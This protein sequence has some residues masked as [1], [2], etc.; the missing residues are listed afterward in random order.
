ML[1]NAPLVV[2]TNLR[3]TF[4]EDRIINVASRVLTR[5][6][7]HPWHI[8]GKNLLT[9]FHDDWKINLVSRVF[10]RKNAPAPDIIRK[11]V[12]TK[13]HEDW[14][15]NMTFRVKNAPPLTINVAYRGKMTRLRGGHVFQPSGAIFKLV[16][17]IITTNLLTEFHEDRTVNVADKVLTSIFR[18]LNKKCDGKTERQ[19]TSYFQATVTILKLVQVETN[20]LTEFHEDRKINV[21]N[22]R[23]INANVTD[24]RRSQNLTMSTLCSKDTETATQSWQHPRSGRGFGLREPE[25][26]KEVDTQDHQ[27]PIQTPD[28]VNHFQDMAPDTKVPNG[29]KDGRT[30]N[31]YGGG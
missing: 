13:F 2:M 22:K 29:R 3:I 21:A 14:T 6:M 23:V 7:P 19:T 25:K 27:G 31:A 5:K 15:I 20:L 26:G 30:D 8:I 4:H 24:K 17:D 18:N 28:R 9:K 16:Q 10:T 12:L 1:K 11:N